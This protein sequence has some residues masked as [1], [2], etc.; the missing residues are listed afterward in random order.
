[1]DNFKMEKNYM[2]ELISLIDNDHPLAPYII[3]I[4]ESLDD[5]SLL[6]TIGERIGIAIPYEEYPP[7]YLYDALKTYLNKKIDP[8][9]TRKVINM[10]Y[11][12]YSGAESFE[13]RLLNF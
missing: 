4:D 13:N 7:S 3:L 5:E 11:N 6:R 2:N 10:N 1:M 8:E 9:I 12:E